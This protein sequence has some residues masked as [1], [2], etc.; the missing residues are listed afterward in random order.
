MTIWQR[1]RMYFIGIFIGT[2]S[3]FFIFRNR[4]CRV[5]TPGT[6]KLDQVAAQKRM[7]TDSAFCLM[8][9]EHIDTAEVQ[10]IFYNG[11]INFKASKEF[12][13]PFPSYAIDGL[14]KSGDS[15]RVYC[16]D[17]N[18]VTYVLYVRNL[19]IKNENCG[20]K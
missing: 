10:E 12:A 6:V 17:K 20:C 16:T 18:F 4:G 15:L 1:A 19:K 13:H 8:K 2:L 11:K 3:V 14:T 5:M 9:C 7:F